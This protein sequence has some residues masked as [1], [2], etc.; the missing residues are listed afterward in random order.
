MTSIGRMIAQFA[1][2]ALAMMRR[3][4]SARSFSASDLPTLMPWACRKVLAMRA[5]D[6]QRI[7]LADQ[8]FQ[9]IELGRDLGAADDAR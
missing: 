6:H 9:E 3:A 2:S 1:A 7:D 4:V 5:A 8:V